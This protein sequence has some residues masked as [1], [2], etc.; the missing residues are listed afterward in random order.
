MCKIQFI[1]VPE[2]RHMVLGRGEGVSKTQRSWALTDWK[3]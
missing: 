2:N 1:K 3:D